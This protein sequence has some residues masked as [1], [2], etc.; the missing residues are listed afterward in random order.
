MATTSA[1]ARPYAQAAFEFARDRNDLASW[2]QLLRAAAEVVQR[3]DL[4]RVL[5]DPRVS[6]QQWLVLFGDLFAPLLDESRRHFL[7]LLVKNRR[8]PAFPAIA[9]LFAKY[10][11]R[12]QDTIELEVIT[13]VATDEVYQQKLAA[14]LTKHFKHPVSL[15]CT[16][17]ANILGG[18]MVRAGDRVIDGSVRGQLTRLLEFAIR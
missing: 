17:D 15:R 9:D 2:E 7:Q 1:I 14:A 12:Y 16:V 10:R 18:A 8:L 13:A 3:P 5:N 4:S 6:P 11:A